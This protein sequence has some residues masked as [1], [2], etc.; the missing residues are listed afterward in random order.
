MMDRDQTSGVS[1]GKISSLG[2]HNSE[3]ADSQDHRPIALASV[4][5]LILLRLSCEVGDANHLSR[6]SIDYV[7]EPSPLDVKCHP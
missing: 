5:R 7:T 1:R 4:R 3:A 2:N 6:Q